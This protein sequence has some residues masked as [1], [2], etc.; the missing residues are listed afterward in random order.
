MKNQFYV[1]S[2]FV[3]LCSFSASG[4]EKFNLAYKL[5]KGQDYRYRMENTYESVQEV[6]GNEMKMNGEVRMVT[7][8]QVEET[9]KDGIMTCIIRQEESEVHSKGMGMDTTY[10][11]TDAIGKGF[12]VTI[13]REGD[14]LKE[15][16]LDTS[17]V[18]GRALS[19]KLLGHVTFR[20]LPENPVGPGE[21]WT[22]NKVDTTSVGE[23]GQTITT[24]A[25][26]YQFEGLEVKNGHNCAKIS[27]KG[28]YEST[29]KMKQMGMDMYTE[30]SGE[31]SGTFWVD[32]D[33]GIFITEE[34][35]TTQDMTMAITGQQQM[36]IP[37]TQTI[38]SKT[39]LLE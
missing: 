25:T 23:D 15:E 28:T 14:V 35:K 24:S 17:K 7:L 26:D 11:I 18:K 38:T 34:S 22:R 37:S 10:K 3:L 39:I 31:T 16:A 9:D 8:Y 36:T 12:R 1:F 19:L 2:A 13:S 20:K 27:F 5:D 21:K 29:G 30:G 4:Q 33:K 32:L 6:M